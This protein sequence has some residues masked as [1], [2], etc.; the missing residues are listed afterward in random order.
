[1]NVIWSTAYKSPQLILSLHSYINS[2]DIGLEVISQSQ[3]SSQKYYC[4]DILDATG[5]VASQPMK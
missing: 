4:T 5:I 2:P 1:M 3:P